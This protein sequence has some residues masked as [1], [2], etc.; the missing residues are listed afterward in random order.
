MR[1]HFMPYM[2]GS[3]EECIKYGN[4][5]TACDEDGY[6]NLCGYQESAEDLE[7]EKKDDE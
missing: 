5:L 6:C 7:S 1:I 3:V 4:H 2:Y